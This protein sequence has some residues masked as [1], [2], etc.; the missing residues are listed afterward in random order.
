MSWASLAAFS[1]FFWPSSAASSFLAYSSRSAASLSASFLRSSAAACSPA[2]MAASIISCSD[3]P[4]VSVFW[5][6]SDAPFSGLVFF[7]SLSM[8]TFTSPSFQGREGAEAIQAFCASLIQIRPTRTSC[9]RRR[10][11]SRHRPRRQQSRTAA[12][13]LHQHCRQP[14]G[15]WSW[16]TRSRRAC[17]PRPGASR[18]RP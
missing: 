17:G 15:H 16:S 14:S 8:G 1:A 9:R 10:P 3:M 4:D 2:L 7:S 6:A 18:L 11:R 13:R 5:A 12:G